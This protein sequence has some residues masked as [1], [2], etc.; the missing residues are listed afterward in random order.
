MAFA[1]GLNRTF[2]APPFVIY[3]PEVA[4]V[5]GRVP[6]ST[7]FQLKALNKIHR[8]ITMETFMR[9]I[10]PSIW[11][12]GRRTGYCYRYNNDDTCQFKEGN[13]P[14]PFWD[15]FN[16][17]FDSYRTFRLSYDSESQAGREAWLAEFPPDKH[18]VLAFAGATG[19]YPMSPHHWPLQ[20]GLKWVSAIAT[21]AKKFI[22]ENFDGVVFVGIHLRNGGDFEIACEHLS[23]EGTDSYMAS[24]QCT[25]STDRKVTKKMCFP[26]EKE[27]LR[28]TKKIVKKEKAKAVFVATDHNDMI[29]ALTKHLKSLGVKIVKYPQAFSLYVEAAILQSADHFIGNCV[30]SVSS[31]IKRERDLRKKPT[32]YWGFS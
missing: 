19:S 30:S 29:P 1:Q 9:K 2:V 8:S 31:L 20:G 25:H 27:I 28:L 10:A 16:V 15:H 14:G 26:P 11:P 24:P 18:P 5:S 4:G 22:K 13:P 21:K 23:K 32:S 12:K 6:F 7:I 3:P 17:D